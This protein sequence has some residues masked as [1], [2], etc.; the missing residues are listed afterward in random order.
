LD[1]LW[2]LTRSYLFISLMALPKFSGASVANHGDV[3]RWEANHAF[4]EKMR[5]RKERRRAQSSARGVVK[6]W[7]GGDTPT[8]SESLDEDEEEGG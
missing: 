5:A 1:L 6:E 7:G 2:R 3:A 4:N 8:E